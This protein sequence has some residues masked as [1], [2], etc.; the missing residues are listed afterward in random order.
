MVA[1]KLDLEGLT[2]ELARAISILE[3]CHGADQDSKV[4]AIGDP[5]LEE[6]LAERADSKFLAVA[7]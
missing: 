6:L 3:L 5:R 4:S 7:K 1:C 2:Y